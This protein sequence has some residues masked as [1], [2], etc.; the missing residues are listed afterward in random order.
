MSKVLVVEDDLALSAG[1]CFELD[2]SG[3]LTVAAYTGKKARQLLLTD[4]FDLVL[5]DV[6]LPD[7]SGFELCREIKGKRPEL[8]VIFLT[9]NDLE[10]DVLG[11]FDLGAED[12]IT[13]PFNVRILKRRMEVALRRGN[14]GA[15]EEEEFDDGFLCLNLESLSAV[16]NG[17]K[18]TITPNEYK[19]LRLLLA[20]AGSIVTR[21]VLLSRL[22]D[23]D[24]NY[25]DDHTLTVTVNRL[26]AKIE[27]A[28]HSYI[29]TVRG[30]GYIWLGAGL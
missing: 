19:I 28:D 26:R 27:D 4:P 21:Q 9:A 20:G 11:G 14:G 30:M 18:L 25:I 17:E 29:R 12:Y 3:Y 16:R 6:N 1:L 22:W 15:K 23:C 5:L 13:K 7:E 10:E 2:M 24:G 8:P